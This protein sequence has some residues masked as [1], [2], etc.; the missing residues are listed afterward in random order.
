MDIIMKREIIHTQKEN[1]WMVSFVHGIVFHKKSNAGGWTWSLLLLQRTRII[2]SA[3][4][5]EG[6]TTSSYRRCPLLALH[7]HATHTY[8]AHNGKKKKK[9]LTSQLCRD[10]KLNSGYW[11]WGW[12]KGMEQDE[13]KDAKYQVW[14]LTVMVNLDSQSDWISTH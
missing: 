7:A 5:S 3:L 10:R 2:F 8:E 13:V 6:F 14:G 12:G 1:S 4:T 11:V 9:R